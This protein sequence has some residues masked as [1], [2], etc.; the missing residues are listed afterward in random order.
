MP[1][2]MLLW[3]DS[4]ISVSEG[5]RA[6]VSSKPLTVRAI[7]KRL[8]KRG[9]R[10]AAR[11]NQEEALVRR[12]LRNLDGV[13]EHSD[14]YP[15]RYST[16]APLACNAVRAT[17]QNHLH[18][19]RLWRVV[20]MTPTTMSEIGARLSLP[21]PVVRSIVRG[22]CRDG[23]MIR[24]RHKVQDHRSRS[25]CTYTFVRIPRT[26]HSDLKEVRTEIA[27]AAAQFGLR[28]VAEK[29]AQGIPVLKTTEL[30]TLS[31]SVAR[32]HHL[33]LQQLEP[34]FLETT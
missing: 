19:H 23:Y 22:M 8:R 2:Y 4:A 25:V 15:M 11:V 18:L 9:I 16:P 31:F 30:L 28:E 29:I 1:T 20:G 27:E 10:F 3:G 12:E 7:T 5:L 14:V 21:T 6:V 24:S 32:R 33:N 26:E 13:V 17:E 34:L